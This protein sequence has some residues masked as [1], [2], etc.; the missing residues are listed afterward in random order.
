MQELNRLQSN[1]PYT[2]PHHYMYAAVV[3]EE[4]TPPSPSARRTLQNNNNN[5][6]HKK[7]IIVGFVDIDARPPKQS[8]TDPPRPYLSDLCIHP[9]YRRQGIARALIQQCEETVQQLFQK[10]ELYIRVE[11]DNE[12][13]RSMYDDLGYQHQVHD[14][15][16]VR[17]TT[18]LLHRS[19]ITKEKEKEETKNPS[20]SPD[21]N[22]T[23]G[24]CDTK[25]SNTSTHSSSS[26]SSSSSSQDE[27][28]VKA[29]EEEE[30]DMSVPTGSTNGTVPVLDYVV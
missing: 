25:E 19:F 30:T 15:F 4:P 24:S 7:P 6:N 18:M 26:R 27:T 10:D 16:G 12:A 23:T 8:R 29:D 14:I 17:D 3:E 13:A 2:D 1:F 21:E 11:Q 9:Q 22:S 28:V 20:S 5:R